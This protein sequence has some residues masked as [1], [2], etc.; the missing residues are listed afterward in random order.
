LLG[1]NSKAFKLKN[2]K[3]ADIAPS[4]LS[5]MG[6]EIPKLMDAEII[7]ENLQ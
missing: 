7:V 2:G 6:I 5:L 3:L 1:Q 4:I